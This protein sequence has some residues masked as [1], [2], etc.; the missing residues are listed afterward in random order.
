MKKF[1]N[2]LV[3]L[4]ITLGLPAMSSNDDAITG[5]G[6]VVKKDRTISSFNA[7]DVSGGIEVIFDQGNAVKMQI[8]ADENLIENIITKVED[9]VLKIYPE[10]GVKNAKEMNVYLTFKD[11]NAIRASGG[12]EIQSNGKLNFTSLSTELSGGCELKMDMQVSDLTCKLTG[13]CEAVLSGSAK[14]LTIAL[15]GGSELDAS[16]LKAINCSV[17][18]TGACEAHVYAQG[19]LDISASGAS[20]VTYSGN[21]TAIAKSSTGASQIRAAN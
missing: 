16:S 11:V 5:N 15:T 3:I 19:K 10:K 14:D 9:G 1:I 7:I 18:A 12:C 17:E 13:G 8:E 20:E 6:K 2:L 21:P 4:V